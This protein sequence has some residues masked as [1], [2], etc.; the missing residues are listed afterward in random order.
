MCV[1]WG[2]CSWLT[3]AVWSAGG[4]SGPCRLPTSAGGPHHPSLQRYYKKSAAFVLRA[5]AK[6]SGALA[7]SVVDAG[8]LEGLV[9]CLEEFDP[10]VKEAAAWALGNIA[11]HSGALAGAVMAA[12]AAPLLVLCVQEPEVALRRSAAAALGE[13]ARHSLELAQTVADAGAVAQLAPLGEAEDA[14]LRRTA[15]GAL[16]ALACHS[17]DLAEVVVEAGVLPRALA[18]MREVDPASRRASAILLRDIVKHSA[19]LAKLAISAGCAGLL[20]EGVRDAASGARLPALMALGFVCAFSE[21]LALAVVLAGGV[22]A[23]RE[24]LTN[25]PEDHVRAAAAWTAG[26][27]GRH[28]PEHARAAAE[29]GLLPLLVTLL[30]CEEARAS[31]DTRLKAKRALKA[32]IAKCPDAGPLCPL[33]RD[34]A[35]PPAVPKAALRQLAVLLPRDP[36]ARRAFMTGGYL[37]RVQEIKAAGEAAAGGQ[38]VGGA[39][40]PPAS[41]LHPKVADAIARIN[42]AFP[43]E[44]VK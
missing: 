9:L 26:H 18:G 17:V 37:Q 30:S 21:T 13:L 25:E 43:D 29:G 7:Q 38:G 14:R 10:A 12:G 33:L 31:S 19:E 44:A 11:S 20:V 34:A 5:V 4:R 15:T 2:R 6:H 16:A 23:L 35:A 22:A 28:T 36:S 24:A 41:A 3:G 39:A 32:I 1:N 40:T 8:A 42:G 27:L